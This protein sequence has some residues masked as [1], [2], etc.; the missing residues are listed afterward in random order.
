MHTSNTGMI[1]ALL[2]SAMAV[3][4]TLALAEQAEQAEGPAA[5][6]AS[7]GVEEITVSAL[8]RSSRLQ[9]TP[10][11]VTALS[12]E[13][14]D[15][16]QIFNV[17]D[18]A[19]QVPNLAID[20][21]TGIGNAARVF[22]RG[23]GEDQAVFTADPGIGTYVDGVYFAR[24]FGVLFDLVDVDSVEVLRGPQGTL[25]G[26]NTPG[27]AILVNSRAPSLDELRGVAEFNYGRFNEV[28]IRGA[29]SMPLARDLA[30]ASVSAVYRTRDGF[31]AA[32]NIG[33][34][35]NAR[36]V[37]SLR[38]QLLLTPAS[39]LSVRVIADKTWDNSDAFVPVS[40]FSGEPNS[41][42]VTQ[43]GEDPSAR[44]T[45]G[46]VSANVSWELGKV[47]LGSITSY[48]ELTQVATLDNDGELRRISGQ[49]IDAGQNQ[50]SQEVTA[51]YDSERLQAMVGFFYFHEF[52]DYDTVTLI[53]SRPNPA[54]A[55]ARPD[56]SEQV[57]RSYA[58]FGQA[59][60][61]LTPDVGLT[62]GGRY[63]WDEKRFVNNQPSVPGVFGGTEKWRD[64][65]PRVGL[66][67]RVN[68]QLFMFA[69][70]AQGFK[71]GGFNRSNSAI[72]ANT[73]YDPENVDTIEFG[74]K[75]DLADRKL[76]ANLTFFNNEYKGL[77]LSA[78]DLDTGTTRRFNAASARTRG[79]ELETTARPTKDFEAFFSV[80]YLDARY[81][82]FFDLVGGVLTDV[83][84]RRL[85]GAPQLEWTAGFGWEPEL[86]NGG[87][88][89]IGGDVNFRDELFNNVANTPGITTPPRTL[90]NGMLR[91]TT[92]DRKLQFT[93]SGRNLLNRQFPVNGIF[94][95]NLISALYPSEPMTWMLSARVNF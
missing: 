35:V 34:D 73:P 80:G 11:A 32:P 91:Y 20:P 33:R 28:F 53:G 71:A 76:R 4:P 87:T 49:I 37:A 85:K 14:L 51:R 48:R 5:S 45:M 21:V 25:F 16:R 55:I 93:A 69:S 74:L 23:V 56:T 6:E 41:L 90:V 19:G 83:S 36:D 81:N 82:E 15:R 40:N 60:F 66:D 17:L 62:A 79:L 38:G 54:V 84:D 95:G 77:Q 57:T 94:I 59:T 8:R 10:V 47:T 30:A 18:V 9:D 78:F 1:A 58:V 50:F 29:L 68:D 2:A 44:F 89:R 27:G 43:A 46:G 70:Y 86:P 12:A 88:I 65:S 92:P 26:R 63:T 31:V 39:N 52:N 22:L 67:W 61:K 13:T 3:T 64:F 7:S 24:T 42:L 72:V 75:A